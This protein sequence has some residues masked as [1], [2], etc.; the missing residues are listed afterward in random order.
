[1]DIQ[2]VGI[3]LAKNVFQMPWHERARQAYIAQATLVAC[4]VNSFSYKRRYTLRP[5]SWIG[6]THAS[7]SFSLRFNAF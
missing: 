4:V 5:M 1:M 7:A 3:D 6:Y 2:T